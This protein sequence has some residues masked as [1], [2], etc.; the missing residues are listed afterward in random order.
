[1]NIHRPLLAISNIAKSN[2]KELNTMKLRLALIITLFSLS[3]TIAQTP[4]Q[5][6]QACIDK[7]I[8]TQQMAACTAKAYKQADQELNALYK[9]ALDTMTPTQKKAMGNAQQAWIIFRDK[10]CKGFLA[11]SLKSYDQQYVS[12]GCMA[13]LSWERSAHLTELL[14]SP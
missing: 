6:M 11:A 12:Q 1:M 14:I 5:E 13:E 2:K 10:Y 7:A 4:K 9:A 8:G 3:A